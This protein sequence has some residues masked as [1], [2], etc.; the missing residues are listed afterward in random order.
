MSVT[1]NCE[2]IISGRY[3]MDPASMEVD[4]YMGLACEPLIWTLE[5]SSL[6]GSAGQHAEHE[7][8]FA[9]SF[10]TFSLPSSCDDGVELP[11]PW[12]ADFLSRINPIERELQDWKCPPS[13]DSNLM[14]LAEAYRGAALIHLY[15]VLRC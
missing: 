10:N 13:N 9:V 5:T 1:L 2:P 7:L 6:N 11:S 12:H 15:R 14:N 4:A 8:G 3:W